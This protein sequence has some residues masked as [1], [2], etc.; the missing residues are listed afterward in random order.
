MIEH[1]CK[2]D[3]CPRSV[4]AAKELKTTG[5]KWTSI[6][7][8]MKEL[9]K[10]LLKLNNVPAKLTNDLQEL[11]KDLEVAHQDEAKPKADTEAENI[12]E[13]KEAIQRIN[14]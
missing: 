3:I 1:L 13:G 14:Y 5:W 8:E 6:E 11:T 10:K 4:P 2:C 7:K 12:K 9:T